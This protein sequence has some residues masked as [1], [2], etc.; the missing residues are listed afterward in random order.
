MELSDIIIIN[1]DFALMAFYKSNE[2]Y[3]VDTSIFALTDEK[4]KKYCEDIINNTNRYRA[5]D[6]VIATVIEHLKAQYEQFKVEISALRIPEVEFNEYLR[7]GTEGSNI[8]SY[9]NLKKKLKY[10]MVPFSHLDEYEIRNNECKNLTVQE[11]QQ[12]SNKNII[13]NRNNPFSDITIQNQEFIYPDTSGKFQTL[14]FN[15]GYTMAKVETETTA[16]VV[17]QPD[18]K[19]TKT[20]ERDQV[21]NTITMNNT[22]TTLMPDTQGDLELLYI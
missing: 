15:I 20:T 6:N 22:I 7:K 17:L 13:L 2:Q 14:Q 11:T 16:S 1:R 21:I 10:A 12:T 9:G 8:R 3:Q 18:F 5:S 19:I 4:I